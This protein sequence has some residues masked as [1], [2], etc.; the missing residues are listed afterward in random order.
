[1][2]QNYVFG[3]LQSI[4]KTIFTKC[5]HL[6]SKKYH[7][8]VCY[9]HQPN[10]DSDLVFFGLEIMTL[11]RLTILLL[12]LTNPYTIVVLAE[13]EAKTKTSESDN[14]NR[15]GIIEFVIISV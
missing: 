6:Q 12:L 15:V 1:M 8:L 3:S 5:L 4:V 7:S 13:H 2:F 11:L 14:N 10:Q 9:L